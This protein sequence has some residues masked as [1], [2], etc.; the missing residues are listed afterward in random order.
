MPAHPPSPPAV[1]LERPG[2]CA[3]QPAITNRLERGPGPQPRP[4]L[5]LDG[6]LVDGQG[7]R[8]RRRQVLAGVLRERERPLPYRLVVQDEQ[9]PAAVLPVVGAAAVR[10]GFLDEVKL[11][12]QRADEP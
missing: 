4:L 6:L 7:L 2:G 3:V 8:F 1:D 11:L 10:P 12:V 9:L 5:P